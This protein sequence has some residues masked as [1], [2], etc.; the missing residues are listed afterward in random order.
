MGGS[1]LEALGRV[2]AKL[3]EAAMQGGSSMKPRL[4]IIF[5]MILAAL[6]LGLPST[7]NAQVSSVPMLKVDVPFD[8]IAG[9]SHLAAGT[10]NIFHTDSANLMMIRST[11]LKAQALVPVMVSDT[12]SDKSVTKL[13][14]NRYGDQYFL[15][16]IWS[17]PD[18]Q[19]HQCMKCPAEKA[20]GKGQ[21]EVMTL[22]AKP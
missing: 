3:L 12:G 18:S 9:G 15:S 22:T 20:L 10:Y 19:V 5:L 14:F 6:F 21:P 17:G 1:S 11:D 7:L 8:F 13:V 4:I 16:Q 2:P